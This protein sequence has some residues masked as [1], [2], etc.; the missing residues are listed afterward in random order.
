MARA[1]L[2]HHHFVVTPV[3][4][5]KLNHLLVPKT[6]TFNP[7]VAADAIIMLL[8]NRRTSMF[9]QNQTL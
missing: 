8:V 1:G 5:P 9:L 7:T 6:L 2:N 3:R 4:T